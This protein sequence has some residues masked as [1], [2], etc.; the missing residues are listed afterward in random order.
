MGGFGT[1]GG[2]VFL[3]FSSPVGCQRRVEHRVIDGT[4]GRLLYP[5]LYTCLSS[6]TD[7]FTQHSRHCSLDQWTAWWNQT[8]THNSRTPQTQQVMP[9]PILF[10]WR[11]HSDI[12]QSIHT[13]FSHSAG[14]VFSSGS[15]PVFAVKQHKATKTLRCPATLLWLLSA[16]PLH[17]FPWW[18]FWAHGLESSQQY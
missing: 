17:Y 11:L 16:A 5:W 1:F 13:T 8:H 3:F 9:K 2:R 4:L 14:C 15:V 10:Y 12:N 7:S 18:A 6:C